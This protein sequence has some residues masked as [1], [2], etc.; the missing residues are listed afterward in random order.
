MNKKKCQ[1]PGVDPNQDTQ[2]AK[3][4][5]GIPLREIIHII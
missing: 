5:D 4:G 2:C 1:F 3:W